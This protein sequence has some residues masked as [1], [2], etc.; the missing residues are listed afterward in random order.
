MRDVMVTPFGALYSYAYY[1]SPEN[2]YL[3]YEFTM[4]QYTDSGKVDGIST[5]VDLNISF[6][7]YSTR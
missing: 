5:N 2:M 7:D 1:G 4:W 6:M 3:P